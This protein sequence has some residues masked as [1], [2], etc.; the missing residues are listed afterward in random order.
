MLLQRQTVSRKTPNDGMLEI[1]A[2]TAE[3]ISGGGGMLRVATSAGEAPGS[4]RSSACTCGKEG[5]GSHI[6]HF[7][8]S[9]VL[10]SLVPGDEVAL[11]L[12]EP[13]TVSVS[14]IAVLPAT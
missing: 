5:G 2:E 6:H 10:R 9:P 11:E 13:R 4:V 14:P 3:R 1:T 12:A 8:E 7:L